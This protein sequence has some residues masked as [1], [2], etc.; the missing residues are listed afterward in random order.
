[1]SATL[2]EIIDNT[3]VEHVI[4]VSPSDVSG[5]APAGPAVE[6]RLRHVVHFAEALARGAD[7]RFDPV[8][9]DREDL[10]FLQ[11]TGGTTGVSKGAALSH[12][13]LVAN[14]EQFK[15]FLS[16]TLRPGDETVITAL[17][18]Y[19][20]FA[21]MVNFLSY[22]SLGAENWLVPNP[23]DMDDFIRI[24]QQSRCTALTGV[25][26]LYGGLLSHPRVKRGGLLPTARGD[27]RW[28]RRAPRHVGTWKALTGRDIL[29]G[30][31]LSETSPVLTLNPATSR[32]RSR[33]PSVCPCRR[34]TS[35]CRTATVRWR[36]ARTARSAPKGP[37][38]MKGYWR[39][40]E[41]NAAAFT[42]DGYFRTGDIGVFDARGSSRSWTARR[43]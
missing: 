37:Q 6:A 21:L 3:P 16:N 43:T 17:P 5:V 25:N 34:R 31:G 4:S 38:V 30:Y 20:I 24:L 42:A 11:Y 10:L 39:K 36:S 9:L 22:F 33:P 8:K 26:T 29:E 14:T 7:L 35:S 15:A 12:R 27:R 28:G 18:L 2:A 32:A 1:M 40:P 19:H 41:A 13:N 23:R